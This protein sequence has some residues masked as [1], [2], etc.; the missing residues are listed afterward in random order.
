M[1]T[2]RA[3][4]LKEFHKPFEIEEYP[5]PDPEPGAIVL[6][7]TQAGLCGSDLHVWRGQQSLQTLPPGGR[8]MGHEGNGV[9]A[10]LGAGV[11]TDSLGAPIR[12][13]DRVMHS[14]VMPCYRCYYCQRGEYNWCPAYPSNREAGVFPYFV[15]TFADY[16]YL[17]P[18]HPLYI[19]PDEIPDSVLSFVNCALGTVTEGLT[20]AGAGAGQTVVIQGAGGLGLNATAVANHM[21]VQRII[22]LDRQKNRLELAREFGADET[23]NIDEYDTPQARLERVRQLTGGRGADIVMELV[24]NPVLMEE[25]VNML[26][27]GG[28]FV[29]IGAVQGGKTAT[30]SPAGLL[31]GKTIMGSLMYRPRML[32]LLLD[33]LAKKHEQVPFHKI[34]SHRYPLD[35]VNAAFAEAEWEGRQTTV[36]RALLIP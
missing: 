15:G 33:M 1:T 25:G 35:Q 4:V 14:A 31:R 17:P 3:V 30:I 12:E 21:G 18:N 9:I 24:G 26:A 10:R 6:K 16:Y 29:Q 27:S 20:R 34:I 13:G 28:A 22:I 23:I 8:V 7:I 36:T 19:V 32:P 11:T 5:V 2:G